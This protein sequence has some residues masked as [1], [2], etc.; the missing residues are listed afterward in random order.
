MCYC[1]YVSA[2]L[3]MFRFSGV[4]F[5]MVFCFKLFVWVFRL[6]VGCC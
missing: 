3:Y 2:G 1:Y 5:I 6:V 4:G